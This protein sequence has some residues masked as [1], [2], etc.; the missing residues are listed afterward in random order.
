MQNFSHLFDKVLYMFRTGPLS[1]IRSISTL[2]TPQQVFV[3]LP[4]SVV[5]ATPADIQLNQHEKYLLRIYSVE[6]LLVMDSGNVRNMQST[7][8]NKFDKFCILLVFMIRIDSPYSCWNNFY[9]YIVYIVSH[10]RLIVFMFVLNRNVLVN[11]FSFNLSA[12][13]FY[14]LILAHPV[15]K[16]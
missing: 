3:M 15:R 16:M 12:P 10:I 14:I 5:R 6:I 7:L 9:S 8:T 2:Y 13:E 1:I 11:L 4:A